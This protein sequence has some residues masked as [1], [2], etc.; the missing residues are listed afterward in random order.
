[1][2]EI[3]FIDRGTEI[4]SP[5]SLFLTNKEIQES[6]PEST[7][8]R[9][10]FIFKHNIPKKIDITLGKLLMNKYPTVT[11]YKESDNLERMQYQHLKKLAVKE[12]GVGFKETF[13]RKSELID[14]IRGANA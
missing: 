12:C 3:F 13:I 6:Y 9:L 5:T 1:M 14:M 11:F 7:Q 10:S 8:N 2:T 4:N